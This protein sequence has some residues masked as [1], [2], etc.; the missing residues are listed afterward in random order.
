MNLLG[1]FLITVAAVA[2]SVTAMLLVRRRAPEGSYFT[3]GDRASGVFGVLASGFAI[4]L[5]FIVFLAFTSYDASRSG[6]ETEALTVS[7]QVETAQLFDDAI[8]TKLT[9]Q[10]VCYAR[11]VAGP[12]WEQLQGGTLREG[13]NPWGA[14]LYHTMRTIDPESNVEQSAFD[15]WLDETSTRE[16]ARQDRIHGAVGVIPSPLW[17]ILFVISAIIFAYVLFF[18]DSGEGP[19]TQAMLMGSVVAVIVMLLLLL[20]FLDNP[21]HP[22]AGALEPVAMQRTLAIIDDELD[23]VGLDITFPCDERGN[24]T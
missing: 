1:S 8:A 18:A 17:V 6:A 13:A 4:L 14:E 23:I 22:G 12:E 24:A 7:Q 2:V 16:E 5:G 10:L 15:K 21:M 11:S 20:R 9:G 3:D 19:V